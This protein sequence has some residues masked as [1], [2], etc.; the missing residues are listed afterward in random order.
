M[1]LT[2]QDKQ[3]IVYHK[4]VSQAPVTPE[5]LEMIENTHLLQINSSYYFKWI[6]HVDSLKPSDAY[7]HQ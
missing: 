2:I 5:N 1:A 4:E 7:M 6:Q 3:V